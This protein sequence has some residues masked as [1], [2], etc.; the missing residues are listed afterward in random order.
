MKTE[1]GH[2]CRTPSSKEFSCTRHA[3]VELSWTLPEFG[4]GRRTWRGSLVLR[5]QAFRSHQVD[6]GDA[7]GCGVEEERARGRRKV[8]KQ[9][10]KG[11]TRLREK[12]RLPS[13][14][15]ASGEAS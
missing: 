11:G 10:C 4:S 5:E 14:L 13:C 7:C 9:L 2:A 1:G 6:K 8:G 12:I 3:L 15:G